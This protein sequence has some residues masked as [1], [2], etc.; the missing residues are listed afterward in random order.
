MS[1][2][3]TDEEHHATAMLLGG[4]Y[5]GWGRMYQIGNTHIDADTL[6]E[7]T[8]DEVIDRLIETTRQASAP[9]LYQSADD[10]WE[11]WR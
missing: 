10:Y 9:N 2:S 3:K 7:L 5:M 8:N 1:R 6:Q 11:K 4:E